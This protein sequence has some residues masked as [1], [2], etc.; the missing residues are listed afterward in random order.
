MDIIRPITITDAMLVSSDVTEAD[1]AEFAMGTTYYSGDRCMVATG[2]EILT[3]DVAPATEW[4]PG[5]LITGQSSG[6]ACRAVEKVT[7]LTYRVRERTGAFTLG[8]IVGVTGTAAK[9]ADQGA[10]HPT[11]TAAADKIH[12]IY[13]ALPAGLELLTLDVAPTTPW[14]PNWYITG[15]TSLQ[16]CTVVEMLSTLTYLVKDRTGAFT[17]GE[18]VGVTGTAVLLA[19]QGAAS[20]VFTTPT[21]VGHYPPDDL[22]LDTPL[23]WEEVSATNRWAAFDS[24]VQSQTSQ[25]ASMTYSL[26]PGLN[27]SVALLNIEATSISLV[28]TDPTDGE[29]YNE[30]INLLSSAAIVDWYTYFFEAFTL[31]ADVVRLAMPLYTAAQL[32]ITISY[33]GGT[34]KIGA[35]IIGKKSYLGVTLYGPDIGI[36]DYSIKSAD[37]NGNYSIEERAYSRRISCSLQI[38]NTSVDEVYRLL[39]LYRATPLVW[40]VISSYA[41]MIAYGFYK[42]FSIVMPGPKRSDCSIDIESLT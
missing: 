24:K 4:G 14:L 3:L 38:A 9:L 40:I 31:K 25:A 21:N 2:C 6:K 36:T 19:D 20:P 18:I 28:V 27:D 15:Q 11:I 26:T 39:S 7:N 1:Y 32:D 8:E 12:K 34:A 16:S 41:S 5:D 42:D 22:L 17:L 30:T 29:V 10:A 35:I 23:W 13:E 33:A 37:E